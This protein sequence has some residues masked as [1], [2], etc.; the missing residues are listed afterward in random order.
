MKE[1]QTQETEAALVVTYDQLTVEYWRKRF[2]D[3]Q[4]SFED[5]IDMAQ[6]IGKVE[7]EFDGVRGYFR[8]QNVN[9]KRAG[10]QTTAKAVQAIEQILKS[11]H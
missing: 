10:L 1:N 5:I 11:R 7:P 4:S 2:A 9:R 6:Q 3:L 8:L